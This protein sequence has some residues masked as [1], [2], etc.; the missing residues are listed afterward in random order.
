[1]R[2]MH[3]V[4]MSPRFWGDSNEDLTGACRIAARRGAGGGGRPNRAAQRIC[5]AARDPQR[6]HQRRR[7]PPQRRSH[8]GDDGQARVSRRAC[9]KAIPPMSRR[10]S[11]ANGWCPA[12]SGRWS[13]T[14]IMTASRSRPRTGSRPSRS[15][16]KLYSDRLDRGGQEIPLPGGRR[17]R[18]TPNGGSTAAPRRTTSSASWRSSPRSTRSRP[19]GK[20]PAFNL[21][22]FFE[23]EEEAGSP[24]LAALLAKHRDTLK[25][26]GWVIFD[27]PAHPS[28]PPQVVA[29][30]ARRR[31]MSTSP[32]T[33]RS[34][35][36]TAAITAIG[37]PI[38]R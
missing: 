12:R 30:R 2:S 19:Q 27:G 3:L 21:K 38:R 16:R 26:D 9:S 13:S 37:C 15:S 22:I 33:G 11:T 6:R 4:P 36:C 35:R 1:M 23:G 8:H 18:S 17:S 10:R 5:R 14:P 24:N 29:R 34:A 31:R 32:S 28:G 20:R 7:H 25:S